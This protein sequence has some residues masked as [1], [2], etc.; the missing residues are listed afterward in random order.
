MALNF[1][2]VIMSIIEIPNNLSYLEL[3]T[4]RQIE[5]YKCIARLCSNSEIAKDLCIS[6]STVEF[7]LAAIYKKL[8]VQN[9]K[10]AIRLAL[11]IPDSN[12]VVS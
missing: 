11:S 3:L 4:E 9:R 12:S 8:G 1:G 10:E 5:V 7:H 2:D 6:E